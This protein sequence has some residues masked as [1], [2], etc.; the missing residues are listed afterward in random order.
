MNLNIYQSRNEMGIAA[1][2]AVEN[3]ITTLLKE[4][5]CL[6]IIFA[7]APSQSEMLNYLASSKTIPWERIIAFHMDEY[8]GLSKDSPALFSNFLR[9][10]L[11]DL[12]PFKKVHLLDGEANPQAE[13]SRYST[14][15]NEAPIDIVC[16]G[17][18]ENGHIAFNDPS[19]ADFEDP[20][21]VKEVVLE[22][23][24]RQQQVNDGCFAKLSEVPETALSLTIPTLINADHLFCVVPGA[25]KKA[26]VYQ[27]LFGQISTQCPG[28]ILRKSEQC[29]LYLDQ[30]SDPFPI[31]QVDKT[32][33]LIGIDVISNRP[34]LV[35]NI[36][37]TRV[38]L[39]NDFEVD[40]Y[41]GEG[42]VDIQING[43]KGVDFNTTVTKPEEI[44][45]ATTYLLS[46]GVT[47]F[48]PTIVTNSF[49]AI[50]ELVRTINKAC[51]SYPIVKA[52]VAGIHLEGPFISCEPGAKGAHPEEFTRKP[53]VAFLDQVQGISVKPISLITLAPE[54]EGSEEFIR[55]CKERGIKVSIGHSLATGDQIQ[56]AKD[57]GVTLATHLGNGVPLNLQRHPNI[58]WEL[59]SQEGITASLIADGFHLPPSF[60]KVAFRAKGDE[61]LLVSDATCFAGMEPGEYESPIGGK[62][63]LEE[64]G[65]L[66]MKGAN[67]L[68][69][70]AG[71]DLL[72]NINYLLESKLLSLSEAWKKASILPLKYM[73]GEKAVN[74]DWVVF[75]IQENE[76]LIKQV[77]KE[78]HEIAVGALN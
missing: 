26:A 39:P 12:V 6:R 53:S 66:S 14:L 69:A 30:D 51:D 15:L 24:C 13:V 55:T 19:V 48:Y 16:L 37:N 17:I 42:L 41:I 38:Q 27:T 49:E 10:H 44:L 7:A 52:C 72:E 56:K 74:K 2:R 61:C 20:Q 63:V 32:A 1:G 9:R 28:T 67:G 59:M 46:K 31:Q 65:R 35:H 40:Q 21:T 34:V 64:S 45:E 36:E 54:L 29:S 75:A 58:I 4:K 76:V 18:G 5:E 70:G 78:G 57:A 50:L 33:N 62:V 23:P 43:I 71:K 25:A 11:F 73:L 3:K 68:L 22:T 8:I 77:Y 60:L 47:T